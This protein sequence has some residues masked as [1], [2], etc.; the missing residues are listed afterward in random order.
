M[1]NWT[2]EII[3]P[4]T[5]AHWNL[6]EV[7]LRQKKVFSTVDIIHGKFGFLLVTGKEI[8]KITKF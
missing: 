8:I 3:N 6:E 1:F 4:G 7:E 2:F 5:K